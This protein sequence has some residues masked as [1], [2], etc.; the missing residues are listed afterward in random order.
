M[1]AVDRRSFGRD[2]VSAARLVSS[3]ITAGFVVGL[4]VGG[5]GGRLAMFVLRVT[6]DASLTGLE[7]DDGFTIGAFTSETLFLILLATIV[8]VWSGFAYVGVR[9][10]FPRTARPWVFGTLA[11]TVGGAVVIRPEGLDFTALEPLWLAVLMFVAIP[12]AYGVAIPLLTERLISYDASFGRSPAWIAGLAV[13]APVLLIVP[14][15]AAIV[16]TVGLALAIGRERLVALWLSAPVS[17][18]GRTSI[19]LVAAVGAVLLA[20]DVAEVL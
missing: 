5:V 3:G 9:G 6:S 1:Q 18:V 10:W 17:W 4:L 15:A 19:A 11:G 20:R 16:A 12:A 14:P 7:T 2:A 8:G 13:A